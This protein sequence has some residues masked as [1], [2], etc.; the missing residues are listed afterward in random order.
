VRG[1]RVSVF[2]FGLGGGAFAVRFLSRKNLKILILKTLT[3]MYF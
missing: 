3:F 1:A 2:R